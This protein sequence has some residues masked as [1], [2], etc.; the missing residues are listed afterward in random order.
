M[1]TIAAILAVLKALPILDSWFSGLVAAYSAWKIAAHDAAFT[2]GMRVLIANHDQRK[3]EEAA[4]ID[5]G[6]D[7]NSTELITRP[8]REH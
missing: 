1:S 7:E 3:L 2:E 6:P 4:G 8:R 5:A